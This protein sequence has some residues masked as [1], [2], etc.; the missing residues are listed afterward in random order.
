[1]SALRKAA[2][3]KVLVENVLTDDTGS[4]LQHI[5]NT[6]KRD[7]KD[8]KTT[9]EISQHLHDALYDY[10]LDDMPYGVQKARDGDPY[11]WV[12][13]RF[14][15]DAQ[16]YVTESV[17][18]SVAEGWKDMMADVKKRAED[19]KGS[20]KFDKKKNPDSGGTIYT[21]KYDAKTGETEDDGKDGSG[22]EKEKR[23]RGRPRTRPLP[24]ENTPRKGRGRP[25]KNPPPDANAPKR[26]R[27]RPKKVREWIE[28][29]RF[30]AESR[31]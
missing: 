3:L 24:D 31:K 13:Q 19:E 23:G 2:G 17:V 20:G 8:F 11:E 16:Q 28:T 6:F 15:Q 21:R 27:G 9:G 5:L 22:E 12:H 14:E 30:V 10:Y 18:Q 29:L 25:R 4:T 26:G 7:V 1:M